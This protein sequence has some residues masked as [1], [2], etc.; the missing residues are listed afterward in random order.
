MLG[1]SKNEPED[2][3]ISQPCL[4]IEVLSKSTANT[5]RREKLVAYQSITSLREY[6]LVAQNTYRVE[7]Y[8]RL[9]EKGLWHLTVYEK[10]DVV[11]F[12]CIDYQL[13]LAEIY[14]GILSV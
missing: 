12:S 9:D 4:I 5:D 1:C 6:Y 10:G 13:E 3:F 14:A 7:R 8:H 2:Y 11:E